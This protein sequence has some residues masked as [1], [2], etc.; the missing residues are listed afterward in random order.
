MSLLSFRR[1]RLDK[2]LTGRFAPETSSTVVVYRA[3]AQV[4]GNQTVNGAALLVLAGHYFPSAGSVKLCVMRY[5]GGAWA[6]VAGSLRSVSSSDA[7]HVTPAGPPLTVL[8][9]DYLVNLGAD[10][11]LV[12]A[13]PAFDGST[14]AIYATGDSAGTPIS[15][16]RI[17]PN[18]QGEYSYYNL[19]DKLWEMVLSGSTPQ[20]FRI[21]PAPLNRGTTLP[22]SGSAPGDVFLLENT[23]VQSLVYTWLANASGTYEWR[24]QEPSNGSVRYAHLYATSG[25][26]TSASP[27]ATVGSNPVQAALNALPATGGTV[28]MVAG[29][30]DMGSSS[31]AVNIPILTSTLDYRGYTFEGQSRELVF[32]NYSGTGSV[33]RYAQ[34]NVGTPGSSWQSN[35]LV[36]RGFAVRQTGTARTGNGFYMT[37]A[38][39]CLYE[40]L[41]IGSRRMD[42][43][44]G[45]PDNGFA[46]GI[47]HAGTPGDEVGD[48]NR[49][50]RINFK[51]HTQAMYLQNQ[52][53]GTVIEEC[54]FEPFQTALVPQDGLYIGN[55]SGISIRGNT[56]NFFQNNSSSYGIKIASDMTAVVIEGNYFEQDYNSII[57]D[58]TQ[59]QDGIV[60][61]GNSF[62]WNGM[63]GTAG[64]Y[65]YGIKAGLD[66]N[67]WFV[68]GLV[69]QGNSFFGMNNYSRAVKL[70]SNVRG[71]LLAANRY[72][73]LAGRTDAYTN[74]LVG[75]SAGP[76]ADGIVLERTVESL[77]TTDESPMV[78]V[79]RMDDGATGL[80]LTN[81]SGINR[82]APAIRWKA[83]NTPGAELIGSL[84]MNSAGT[85]RFLNALGQFVHLLQQNGDFLQYPLG[86]PNAVSWVHGTK[87]E[88]II[89]ATGSVTTDSTAQLLPANSIIEAVS[90]FI[91][92]AI[93]TAATFSIG[94]DSP[95]TTRFVNGA[96]VGTPSAVALAF[97]DA[98]GAT[99]P[100]NATAKKIRITT[101]VNPG[102]GKI[103][104][105]VHYRQFVAPSA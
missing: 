102:A 64:V 16:S 58:S 14:A 95:Q 60:I 6:L 96:A 15:Q 79:Y 71:F 1:D 59:H 63:V 61:Q 97:Q 33:F 83:G 72:E 9:G 21:S 98:T 74:V 4:K 11:A 90:Y 89:L 3:G 77:S 99:G 100:V 94:D 7:T 49:F 43:Q 76:G 24:I 104:V 52:A 22:S 81:K 50:H 67:T 69:I 19:E 42:N 23:G 48:F 80:Q 62:S 56:F 31:V 41:V 73:I 103:R 36:F 26:G 40:D 45:E 53:D 37:Y 38:S 35:Q 51:G 84:D 20:E 29:H 66:S 13:T 82:A 8:D 78:Q 25:L 28:K 30:Y 39:G 88:E 55:S 18:A 92:Q 34:V 70:D 2:V 65:T 101:N 86:S 54:N 68:R 32:L 75:P 44:A 57:L 27:W 12:G 105:V 85:F 91:T 47:L 17:T 87:T 5:S 10:S 46:Y 93:T